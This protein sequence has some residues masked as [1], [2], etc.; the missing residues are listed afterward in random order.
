MILCI[1][2][3]PET[4]PGGTGRSVFTALRRG[5]AA[6]FATR[7]ALYGAII[8]GLTF[9]G[10][11]SLVTLS[12][13]VLMGEQAL[14]PFGFAAS[15]SVISMGYVAGALIA[16][17]YAQKLSAEELLTRMAFGFVAAAMIVLAAW[18][19]SILAVTVL[20]LAIM[21]GFL[22]ANLGLCVAITMKPLGHVAGVAAACLG[23]LQL[24][25]GAVFSWAATYAGVDRMAELLWVFA[26]L[27]CLIACA[28]F[29]YLRGV[30][31]DA[32]M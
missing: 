15:F 32:N 10:V 14:D 23:T 24:L 22:G 4:L 5:L 28:S 12:P 11:M 26:A 30:T 17:I 31:D 29:A 1:F 13:H 20:A 7:A 19:I 18:S 21:M 27:A 3:V 6:F 16:R 8:A 25:T 9:W 2:F